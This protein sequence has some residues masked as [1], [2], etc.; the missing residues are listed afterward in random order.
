[1]EACRLFRKKVVSLQVVSL[2]NEVVSLQNEVDSL[3]RILFI[4]FVFVCLGFFFCLWRG[5]AGGDTKRKEIRV[6]K[7][8]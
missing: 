8:N 3:Q 1:M 5:A 7:V 6:E 4:V 2:Q